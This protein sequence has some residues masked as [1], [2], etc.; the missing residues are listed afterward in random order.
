MG[1][2]K[3]LLDDCAFLEGPRWHEGALYLS[4]M[5]GPRVLRLDEGGTATTVVEH[6]S[7]VSGLGWLPDGSMVVVEMGGHVLRLDGG[8][9]VVHADVRPLAPHG[10]NDMIS[11]PDGWN[12]VG[13]FGY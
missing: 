4:D 2:R 12:W 10:I 7:P 13:Q 3:I 6:T 1:D 11:H 5:H 9:L 8:R